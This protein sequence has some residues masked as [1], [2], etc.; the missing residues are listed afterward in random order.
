MG[1]PD[2]AWST[3][4]QKGG[5]GRERGW[6]CVVPMCALSPWSGLWLEHRKAFW[7]EV[8]HGSLGESLSHHSSTTGLD[9][10]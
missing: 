1:A 2:A 10:Q 7:L 8:R 9:E 4:G 5:K 6:C 3:L